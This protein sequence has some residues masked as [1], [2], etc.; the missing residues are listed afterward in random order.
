MDAICCGYNSNFSSSSDKNSHPISH[1]TKQK[2]C[3]SS[4]A[5][6]EEEEDI[7]THQI[8]IDL[9]RKIFSSEELNNTNKT[10]FENIFMKKEGR[11]FFANALFQEKFNTVNTY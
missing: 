10:Q 1:Q 8:I 3:K 7:K 5:I 11:T 4:I 9:L 6:K 2:D